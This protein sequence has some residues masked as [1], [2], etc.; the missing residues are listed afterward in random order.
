MVTVALLCP[1]RAKMIYAVQ[2]K[3]RVDVAEAAAGYPEDR[4]R[5]RAVLKDPAVG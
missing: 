4:L 3:R 5:M 1:L 2:T